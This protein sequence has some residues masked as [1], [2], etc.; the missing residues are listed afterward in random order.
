MRYLELDTD[1]R[2]INVIIWDGTTPYDS[3]YTLI[4][5]ADA[6]HATY[7]WQLID[8]TWTAPP[9]DPSE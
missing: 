1:G 9:A 7:G 6:P 4:P 3:G 5:C 8:G 2:V